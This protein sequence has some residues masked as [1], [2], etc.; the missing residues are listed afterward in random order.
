MLPATFTMTAGVVTPRM[1]ASI[2]IFDWFEL[3]GKITNSSSVVSNWSIIH[4]QFL[5]CSCRPSMK[6]GK[7]DISMTT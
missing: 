3:F 1:P 6:H 5:L 2:V 4:A 7:A